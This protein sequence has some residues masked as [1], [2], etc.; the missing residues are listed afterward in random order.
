MGWEGRISQILTPNIFP[1]GVSQ[2][3]LGIESRT[4]D[5]FVT[6]L[7]EPL[8]CHESLL[9]CSAERAFLR[10]MQGGCQVP[11]GVH[12][13][14]TTSSENTT[15]LSLT[16]SVFNLSGTKYIHDG[17]KEVV[18]S[19]NDAAALGARVATLIIEKGG[20]DLLKEFD[21]GGVPRAITYSKVA[22]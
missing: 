10:A 20:A 18:Q 1:Y 11:L 22:Q 15:S 4:S 2:G 21:V 14:I 16:G 6:S 17:M 8:I 19:E 5:T 3:S 13:V 9:R 7:I 12:S